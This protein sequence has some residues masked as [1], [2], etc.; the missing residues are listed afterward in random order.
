MTYYVLSPVLSTTQELTAS[1]NSHN[2]PVAYILLFPLYR[3]H[4]VQRDS[5]TILRSKRK[6]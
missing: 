1:Y 5:T 2:N 3:S 6:W 4:K